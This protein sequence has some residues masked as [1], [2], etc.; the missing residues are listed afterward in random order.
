MYLGVVESGIEHAALCLGSA[1]DGNG[2]EGFGPTL[3]C[4][5]A[6]LVK[7][8]TLLLVVQ[9]FAGVGNRHEA[10]AYL[11][12]NL[13]AL[14]GVVAEIVAHLIAG[15][16]TLI[17]TVYLV[18]SVV[19]VPLCLDAGH[20]RLLLP[21]A[22]LARRLVHAHHEVHGEHGLRVVAECSQQSHAFYLGI[23]NPAD[24]S[25]HLVGEAVAD[26]HEQMGLALLEGKALNGRA[27]GSGDLALDT[28]LGELVGVVARRSLLVAVLGAIVAVVY[29]QLAL[30]GHQQQRAHLGAAH[31]AQGDMGKAGEVLV[32]MH[33]GRRPPAGVLV[34]DV[35]V[36][37]HHIERNH[38]HQAVRPDGARVTHTEI[39]RSDKRIDIIYRLLLC[40]CRDHR[41][42]KQ[43][44]S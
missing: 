41:H 21:E 5:C 11:N 8:E 1:L 37:P 39:G 23:R 12:L 20:R 32:L 22:C 25:S 18:L 35:E 36:G 26:V 6:N 24:A 16:L 30:R 33:I 4:F 27:V 40:L 17:V 19:W 14:F 44:H 9:I 43:R 2:V 28:I 34:V 42:S 3:A 7:L 10:D 15:E 38:R 29:I 13:L 31:T